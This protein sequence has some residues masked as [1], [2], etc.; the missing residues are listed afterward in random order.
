M[1]NVPIGPG[2]KVTLHFSLFTEDEQQIDSTF[3]KKAATFVFGDG[4]LLPGFEQ[5]LV[6]LTVSEGIKRISITPEQGFGA[7][8]PANIQTFD[9]SLFQGQEQELAEGSVI[10]FADAAK[11]ELPGVIMSVSES[12]VTVDFNHPLAGRTLLFDVLIMHV[13]NQ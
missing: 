2:T 1:T 7:R 10:S 13:E 8:N 9:R 11:S 4:N 3:E 12:E 6:G 5:A